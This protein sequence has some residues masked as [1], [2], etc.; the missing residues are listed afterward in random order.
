MRNKKIVSTSK[1]AIYHFA[2]FLEATDLS[3]ATSGASNN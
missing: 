1:Q 3:N 2:H